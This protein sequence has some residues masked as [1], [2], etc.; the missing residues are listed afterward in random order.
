M[1]CLPD[2]LHLLEVSGVYGDVEVGG[3]SVLLTE[4]IF[5][6]EDILSILGGPRAAGQGVTVSF[7]SSSLGR[8]QVAVIVAGVHLDRVQRLREHFGLQQV[9]I[10]KT[11][12]RV[13]R[14]CFLF[15]GN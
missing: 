2:S 8:Q 9:R 10:A 7:L 6:E 1:Q 13:F 5:I 3:S 15:S 12:L 11:E 14:F 4:I